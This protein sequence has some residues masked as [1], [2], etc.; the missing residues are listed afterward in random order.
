MK[1]RRGLQMNEWPAGEWPTLQ[2]RISSRRRR[3]PHYQSK[4]QS[5]SQLARLQSHYGCCLA[6]LREHGLLDGFESAAQRWPP[7]VVA[8]LVDDM[9]TKGYKLGSIRSR[10][11]ALK[12]VLSRLD[13]GASLKALTD[14]IQVLPPSPPALP[15]IVLRVTTAD[16]VSFGIEIMD[17]TYY[18]RNVAS[19]LRFRTGLQ[20][21]HLALRTWR[22]DAFSNIQIGEHLRKTADGWR[23]VAPKTQGRIKRDANGDYPQRLLNYLARYL[24]H[25]RKILCQGGNGGSALWVTEGGGRFSK[26]LLHHFITRATRARFGEAIYP[27]AFRK[28]LT[29]TIAIENPARIHI[30]SVTL[31]H[32]DKVN[33]D[34]YNMAGSVSAFDH[35][36][37]TI[38]SELR[39]GAHRRRR[40]WPSG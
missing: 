23:L 19:A 28:C 39:E 32:G 37:D 13:P 11:E 12:S 35:L 17:E 27:H 22:A 33:E 20:I 9:K 4:P 8:R 16:L 31:G 18:G 7:H 40:R 2:S 15:P 25:H 21:S 34:S 24:E 14:E 29:T 3:D 38:E 5:R 30:A 6:W 36:Q 10:L 26:G 1:K